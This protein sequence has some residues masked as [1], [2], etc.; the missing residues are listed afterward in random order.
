MIVVLIG[1]P[2]SGKG[3]QAKV[4]ASTRG[5]PQLSTG[6]MLRTA[7]SQGTELGQQAKKLMDQG[8]LVPDSVVIGLISER[9]QADD[10]RSGFILDGFPRNVAQA[11]AL[12]K[13]MTSQGIQVDRAVLFSIA[14]EVLVK[15]LSGR[16]TCLECSAMY[17]IDNAKPKKDGIC[18]E[19][20]SKLVQRDDDQVEVVRKRLQVYHE[21]TEPVVDFYRTQGKLKSL[22]AGQTADQVTKILSE[23]LK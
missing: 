5:L 22:D 3:T 8:A 9:S 20:G 17:H 13:M 19:C 11:E 2:G 4:L 16:R 10:C 7:I 6:D 12:D 21:K 15:R 14:D 23:I 18:D 1:P